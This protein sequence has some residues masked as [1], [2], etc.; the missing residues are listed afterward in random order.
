[1][2]ATRVVIEDTG[3]GLRAAVLEDEHRLVELRDQD[4][5]DDRRR[6][7]DEL[8]LARVT[9]V[10]AKLNAAFL[11]CGLPEPGFVAAKDA[12]AAAGGGARRPIRELLREGQKLIVQGLREAAADDKG[13][14]FTTDIRLFGFALVHT[15]LNPHAAPDAG[16]AGRRE[17]DVLRARAAELFA[18]GTFALRSIAAEAPDEVLRGEAG[19]LAAKWA[20]ARDAAAAMRRPGRLA[21]PERPLE[22][23]LRGLLAVGPE[24]IEVADTAL[25]A[26]L[27]RLAAHAPG[28]PPGIELVR[29]PDDRPAF[30]SA[31][32]DEELDLALATDVPLAA[33]GRLRF[34]RTAAFTTVDVDGGG[35]EPLDA[36]LAAVPELARQIRLRNL[37][38][39]IAVDFVT[40]ARRQEQQRL[41]DALRRAFRRDPV[42]VDVHSLPALGLIAVSRARRGEPLAARFLRSCPGCGGGG[43]LPSLRMQA[44]RLLA[45]LRGRTLPPAEVWLAP[46]LQ[47]FLAGDTGSPWRQGA[48]RLGPVP[49]LRAD[50]G[51]P[52]GEF[53]VD[54]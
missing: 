40:L 17:A 32:V 30:A 27:R 10:D 21:A 37:G 48:A 42:P 26:E 39:T 53:A 50:P 49:T 35:R 4:H 13:P 1:M 33:G 47:G 34:E 19:A 5:V 54:R 46:D 43:E 8:F 22:R 12:R 3:F 36:N 23:L 9:A 28:F 41:E 25:W 45:E 51:L 31:G 52:P 16:G 14:R 18:E 29:L 2:G 15:P 11:D 6:V 38:G 20:A 44:E 24:R 7:T